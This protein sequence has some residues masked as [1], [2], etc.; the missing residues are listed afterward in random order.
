MRDR[1]SIG[2]KV[3]QKSDGKSISSI[4]TTQVN[5]TSEHLV[6][7]GGAKTKSIELLFECYGSC[8]GWRK[9]LHRR[10]RI[11]TRVDSFLEWKIILQVKYVC[12]QMGMEKK[13]SA[14]IH[15]NVHLWENL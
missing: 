11:T 12:F 1:N 7:R 6:P 10:H 9:D 5:G 15:A 2:W 8:S 3:K 13:I 14:T 4:K